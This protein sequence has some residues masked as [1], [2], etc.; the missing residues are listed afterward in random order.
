MMMRAEIVVKE[1][2]KTEK[3]IK[4]LPILVLKSIEVKAFYR[5]MDFYKVLKIISRYKWAFKYIE[6]IN[7]NT[8][9]KSI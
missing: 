4:P 3:K 9:Y 5:F 8:N 2:F 6:R 1:L 7:I